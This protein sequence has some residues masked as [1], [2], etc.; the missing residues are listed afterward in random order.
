MHLHPLVHQFAAAPPGRRRGPGSGGGGAC[1]VLSSADDP[2]AARD[3]KRR[4]RRDAADG[5]GVRELPRR[6]QW[7]VAHDAADV[8]TH[9]E[10]ALFN[11]CDHRCRHEEAF[12]LARERP[13]LVRGPD[14]PDARGA[15]AG[16]RRASR[17][18]AESLCRGRSDRAARAGRGA[19]RARLQRK[20]PVPQRPGFVLPAA[21][22]A[23]KTRAVT[24]AKG[25]S[26]RPPGA[27]CTT[28]RRRSTTSRWSRSGSA[29]TTRRCAC[30]CSRWPRIGA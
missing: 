23:T 26:R 16:A 25:C 3:R 17:V 9:S 15:A 5:R 22:G 21:W 28:P 10:S 12:A 2:A 7:A 6:W 30:R 4:S 24:T 20:E 19:P 13:R 29:T 14:G 11:F 1:A 27:T 18:P 8:L